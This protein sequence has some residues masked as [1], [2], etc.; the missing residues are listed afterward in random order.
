MDTNAIGKAHRYLNRHGF[1]DVV[2]ICIDKDSG[3][4]VLLKPIHP[5]HTETLC[6]EAQRL[7]HNLMM[8]LDI[9]HAIRKITKY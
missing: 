4:S 3:E 1:Q 6:F 5:T 2:I 7:I 8:D 9:D